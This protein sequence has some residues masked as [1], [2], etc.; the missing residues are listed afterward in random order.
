VQVTLVACPRFEPARDHRPALAAAAYDKYGPTADA[1]VLAA[2]ALLNGAQAALSSPAGVQADAV[3]VMAAA[4]EVV[5]LGAIEP[6]PVVLAPERRSSDDLGRGGSLAPRRDAYGLGKRRQ[7][8]SPPA[9]FTGLLSGWGTWIRT[10]VDGV[11]I[12]RRKG[13][14]SSI[15]ELCSRLPRTLPRPA[16]KAKWVRST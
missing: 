12:L 10:R 13:V 3:Q 9:R 7:P 6:S 4:G 5:G 8:S 16:Y 2:T 14:R 1:G 11:R 15:V